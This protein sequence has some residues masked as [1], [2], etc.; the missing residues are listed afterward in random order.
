[1][2]GRPGTSGATP[3]PG[4]SPEPGGSRAFMWFL[5]YWLP[6]IVCAVGVVWGALTGG[7]QGLEIAV[8]L[9]AAGSSIWL[10]NLLFRV[11]IKGER[12][13][14]EEQA[15]RDYFDEHG[16]WPDE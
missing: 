5:R 4:G 9:V 2:T 10:M 1:M 7:E 3:P 12:E 6:G 11:G 13:R 8:A 15:A 14:D 16:R